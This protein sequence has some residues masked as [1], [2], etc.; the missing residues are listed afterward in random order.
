MP[1][2]IEKF[3]SPKL[4]VDAVIFV[5]DKIVLIERKNQPFGWAFPGGF[6]DYGESVES[7]VVREVLEET[8]LNIVDQT[9]ENVGV[10]SA[11]ERDPRGHVVSV[12]FSCEATGTPKACDDAK[13][14]KLFDLDDLPELAFDHKDILECF[15]EKRNL[16]QE[17]PDPLEYTDDEIREKF[18]SHIKKMCV[19]WER[20]ND[21]PSKEKLDGL[22]FSFL[23]MLDGCTMDLPGFIVAPDPHPSDKDYHKDNNERYYPDNHGVIVKG[24]ISGCLHELF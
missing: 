6:V 16:K 4:A 22:A 21:I 1:S 19:Y 8:T 18:L 11:P 2:D 24:D 10:Y 7:A 3:K 5:G 13:N 12:V 23:T 20:M 14:I 9:L 17:K 15:L